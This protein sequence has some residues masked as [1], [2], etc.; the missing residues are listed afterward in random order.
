MIRGPRRALVTGASSGI[1]EAT[2]RRLAQQGYRVAL[3]ARRAAE[4]E[5]VRASM[6][7]ADEHL[8]LACDLRDDAALEQA[9]ERTREAFGGLDLLV[10][11]AG[12][13][14][15]ANVEETRPE[16]V[17]ELYE[18]NVA[19]VVSLSRL[20]APLLRSGTAP[21]VVL[22]SSIVA[23]RGVP[24]QAVYASSKA[25][26]NSFGE[27]LRI[28]WAPDRIAVC[29]LDVG[30]T[31]TPFFSAQPNPSQRPGPNLAGADDP[32]DVAD[33]ILELDR[34]PQPERW[35]SW[36]WRMLALV[37]VLAPR[38]ADRLLVRRMGGGWRA[39]ER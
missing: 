23:R 12:H 1:G 13:G 33:A 9:V 4:L 17:R 24:G 32:N 3:L 38:L 16:L 6:E 19:S 14:Y 27:A 34:A 5:R 25:A 15:L 2:V 21:V 20:A 35:L 39:P 31:R 26:L 7:R 29:T 30:L 22:V 18:L 36:K 8:T 28:E 37:N 11:N 10:H